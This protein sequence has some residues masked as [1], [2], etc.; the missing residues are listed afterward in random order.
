MRSITIVPESCSSKNFFTHSLKKVN[1]VFGRIAFNYLVSAEIYD[2]HDLNILTSALIDWVYIGIKN[3]A[4]RKDLKAS[5]HVS[6]FLSDCYYPELDKHMDKMPIS[7]SIDVLW[8]LSSVT[9]NV[10]LPLRCR[11][12]DKINKEYKQENNI[13]RLSML[14]RCITHLEL[15]VNMNFYG[16]F[17]YLT[18]KCNG[19]SAVESVLIL[20]RIPPQKRSE[21]WVD[22]LDNFSFIIDSLTE[23][24]IK[25]IFKTDKEHWLPRFK[26]ASNILFSLYN[27][28]EELNFQNKHHKSSRLRSDSI[29]LSIT[30]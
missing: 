29:P 21:F 26:M 12:V 7:N 17:Y 25:I 23:K 24:E 30:L 13:L 27:D 4:V 8:F 10:P 22:S 2:I 1:K 15:K 9:D 11:F 5:S 3:P 28:Y 6:T 20:G 19:F 14:Y 16:H 18:D